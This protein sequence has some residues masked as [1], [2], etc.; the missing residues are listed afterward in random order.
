M[1]T[2]PNQAPNLEHRAD[3]LNIVS[4]AFN[5]A[6]Q[7]ETGVDPR[8]G[9]YRL[10]IPVGRL[11]GAGGQ[12][13][14]L[15]LAYSF[16]SSENQGFGKGWLTNLTRYIP[17]ERRLILS[18]GS[19][20]WMTSLLQNKNQEITDKCQYLKLKNI[21]VYDSVDGL[22]VVYKDGKKEQLDR[23]GNLKYLI[24]PS[25]HTLIFEYGNNRLTSI[26][27]E[28]GKTLKIIRTSS[29]AP[30]Q[31][32]SSNNKDSWQITLSSRSLIEKVTLPDRSIMMIGYRT[33]DGFDMIE[34][35]THPTKTNEK[36]SYTPKGIR[37]P[38]SS[39]NLGL[40]RVTRHSVYSANVTEISRVYTYSSNTNFLGLGLA[41]YKPGFD[42]LFETKSDYSYSSTEV[43]G[44]KIEITRTYNKYH[45]QIE[46]IVKDK[47]LVPSRSV[48]VKK[49]KIDYYANTSKVFAE[50]PAQYVFPRKKTEEYF[51]VANK[52][53]AEVTE[54]TFDIYG[55]QLTSIDP[56]GITTSYLYYPAKGETGNAPAS[57]SGLP[58]LLKTQ[59]T[60]PSTRYKQGKEPIQE[61][62][63]TYKAIPCLKTNNTYPVIN[64]QTVKIRQGQTLSVE[65]FDYVAN[66]NTKDRNPETH[67]LVSKRS[68]QEGT[69]KQN[70]TF[71]YTE[72]A[73]TQQMTSVSNSVLTN[74][75]PVTQKTVVCLHTGTELES[76]DKLGVKT[77][78]AYDSLGRVTQETLR[79]N[80]LYALTK[81]YV[82]T[83]GDNTSVMMTAS[84]RTQEKITYDSLKRERT[85]DA[86]DTTG[87]LV[88]MQ[89]KKY[90]ALG[91]MESITINEHFGGT[92]AV[93]ATTL[94]EYDIWGE[95][96]KETLPSKVIRV[97]E[98]DKALN[99]VRKYLQASDNSIAEEITEFYNE[100]GKI[101]K[102]QTAEFTISQTYD[103]LG[104]L[105]AETDPWGIK[106][107]YILDNVGR[108]Q[109]EI[110]AGNPQLTINKT[111]DGKTLREQITEIKINDISQ[112][113]REYDALGRVTSEN[114][115]AYTTRQT[116]DTLSD[117]ASKVVL[118]DNSHINYTLDLTLN[119]ITKYYSSDNREGG[120]T[121]AQTTG[122]V[123]EAKNTDYT[124]SK[125]YYINGMLQ[126]ETQSGKTAT[127]TYSRQGQ[128]LTSTDY[129]GQI[130]R[131]EYDNQHRLIKVTKGETTVSITYDK[132]S[133]VLQE[134]II[135]KADSHPDVTHNYTYDN[136][137]RLTRISTTVNSGP[138]LI[139][140]YS[141]YKDG[142]LSKK[143]LRDDNTLNNSEENY[144]Y[145]NYGRL[146]E[147]NASGPRRPHH[148]GG[149][150]INKQNFEFDTLGN[151]LKVTTLFV[152]SGI[153]QTDIAT[154][155]YNSNNLLTDIQYTYP[156]MQYATLSYDSNG[157]LIK[158]KGGRNYEYNVLGQ[159]INVSH[160]RP[161][162]I[163]HYKYSAFGIQL[164]QSIDGQGDIE[165][166][167][168][169]NNLMNEAQDGSYSYF[170]SINGRMLQRNVK[171]QGQHIITSLVGDYK[172]SI[173]AE[174]DRSHRRS[175]IYT[176]Y[177]DNTTPDMN[178]AGT[179]ASTI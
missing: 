126:S 138:Y 141:Y 117:R 172:N 160:T 97:T 3:G 22:L 175:L 65:I 92:L 163:S 140:E 40:P 120:Y 31:F 105:V 156:V 75:P 39:A 94:F 111:F 119:A 116:Y 96:R 1:A 53:R 80:T 18:D 79:A 95:V 49:T 159:L 101:I 55:N 5:L 149:G 30:I 52:T 88:R 73:K 165:L 167:Y 150:L 2:L 109:Q 77:L 8:T 169:Q 110:V 47:N 7:F 20:H 59:T 84:D 78:K 164:S 70:D 62:E 72:D 13:L 151:V 46:E 74:I 134:T 170:L 154:Y 128:L 12:T 48:I 86:T 11:L 93:A 44:D 36:I 56:Y 148:H 90:N 60:L 107:T 144:R 108:R 113:K 64:K 133:R 136:Q 38:G 153:Q 122:R 102:T 173:I 61:K 15:K 166:F 89:E 76:I 121:F 67:G 118:P 162:P 125:T 63:I 29:L 152:M 124:L 103:G 145:D 127:Y 25:E 16:L 27:D 71:Q 178:S 112:G 142:K 85:R 28:A 43:L 143:T 139:Q 82:Y 23:N 106:R 51:N 69:N 14:E 104:R 177:G 68:Y 32:V 45:L 19:S 9:I 17:G 24:S 171:Y 57:I 6:D 115:G 87:A 21:R 176:P 26:K 174:I 179:E 4:T 155:T 50:Q 81:N 58:H 168:G 35:I 37:L 83:V 114:K 91:Q 158:D 98:R 129:F 130:E 132:F 41:K 123:L 42:N 10:S 33:L 137:S 131:R 135:T 146:I 161:G 99:T 34:S 54:T 66:A 147:L 157:N 100:Q